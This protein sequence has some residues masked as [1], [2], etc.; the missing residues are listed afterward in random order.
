MYTFTLVHVD[1]NYKTQPFGILKSKSESLTPKRLY[2]PQK[3][4]KER[5]VIYTDEYFAATSIRLQLKFALKK[6]FQNATFNCIRVETGA[7][8]WFLSN[9]DQL[10]DAGMMIA[11]L[12]GFLIIVNYDSIPNIF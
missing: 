5:K 3:M 7:T 10:F 6:S 4:T 1:V 12:Y 8:D 9:S 2:D 11:C